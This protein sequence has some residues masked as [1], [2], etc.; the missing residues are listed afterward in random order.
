MISNDFIKN[1]NEVKQIMAGAGIA[2]SIEDDK[3]TIGLIDGFITLGDMRL[4]RSGDINLNT[5]EVTVQLE[6]PKKN[7]YEMVSKLMIL[8]QKFGKD[9]NYIFDGFVKVADTS[10]LIYT[11][12]INFRGYSNEAVLS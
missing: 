5:F 4:E 11:G 12:Q 6:A 1:I 7:W 8:T 3:N 2:V 9:N 10:K